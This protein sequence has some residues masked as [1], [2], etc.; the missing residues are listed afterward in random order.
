MIA[1]TD[2]ENEQ[3]ES[4]T[5]NK[6]FKSK[7]FEVAA[8]LSGLPDKVKNVVNI[9]LT[10]EE[11]KPEETLSK[12]GTKRKKLFFNDSSD[13]DAFISSS[14]S[15]CDFY[16]NSKQNKIKK[17][18]VMLSKITSNVGKT[19]IQRQMSDSDIPFCDHKVVKQGDIRTFT[20]DVVEED[21]V[22]KKKKK[23]CSVKVQN[24]TANTVPPSIVELEGSSS[25]THSNEP[26]C[27]DR[28]NISEVAVPQIHSLHE[29][30]P[31]KDHQGKVGY[32]FTLFGKNIATKFTISCLL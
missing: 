19:V 6:F 16:E 17:C 26:V 24:Q 15:T 4:D 9:D 11:E 10:K 21:C 7:A 29:E 3:S 22:N 27:R 23:D 28:D 25:K 30:K 13:P 8:G 5:F 20:K 12:P 18:S 2:N 31:D 32:Y 1:I 14:E